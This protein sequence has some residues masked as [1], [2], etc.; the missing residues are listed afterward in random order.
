MDDLERE[1][2]PL[3]DLEDDSDSSDDNSTIGRKKSKLPL[4]N[5][6]NEGE[7][8]SSYIHF[9]SVCNVEAVRDVWA[10]KWT[11]INLLQNFW[12]CCI[13]ADKLK[14]IT[15]NQK[16]VNS[17]FKKKNQI[18]VGKY[19]GLRFKDQIWILVSGLKIILSCWTVNSIIFNVND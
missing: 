10:S 15:E 3:E 9:C 12:Y 14:S 6:M 16:Y 2:G 18:T 8:Y 13:V 11:N 4:V 7:L 5:Q 19:K 17:D 1:L